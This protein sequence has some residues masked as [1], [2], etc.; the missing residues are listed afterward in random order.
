[1]LEENSGS[2][3]QE[4]DGQQAQPEPSADAQ[5]SNQSYNQEKAYS[6][7][8]RSRAQA[9]ESELEKLQ[10]RN[11]KMEEDN[12]VNQNKY[13]ELWDKDKSD[14]EWARDY[15]KNQR[16]K[17]L[18]SLPDDKREKFEKMNL[19]FSALQAIVEEFAAK[20]PAPT[21]KAVPGQVGIPQ[22]DKPYSDMN[23]QERRAFYEAASQGKFNDYLK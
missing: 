19:N 11:K 4:N 23:D 3:S 9:A 17:M 13:K 5:E 6:A 10:A 20:E 14:A 21:M 2:Q 12:L 8:L 16:V 18:D 22:T 7:K 15:K 1:M